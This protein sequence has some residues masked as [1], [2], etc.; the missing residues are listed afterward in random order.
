MK[1]RVALAVV[2][3]AASLAASAAAW[4][5]DVE[6]DLSPG[7]K[8][9]PSVRKSMAKPPVGPVIP[10][11]SRPLPDGVLKA[12]P[13][14]T[15]RFGGSPPPPTPSASAPPPP[16]PT[17]P[18]A[19]PPAG[20]T[21]TAPPT[22]PPP[23]IAGSY[24]LKGEGNDGVK[25]TGT[26]TMS[27]IGGAMY[28]AKWVIGAN[29]FTGVCVKETWAL[30]CAWAV[31][32][33]DANVISYLCPPSDLLDGVWFESGGTKLGEEKLAPIGKPRKDGSGKYTITTGQNPDGST[34]M[35]SLMITT[36]STVCAACYKLE[37]TIGSGT[38]V[39]LGLRPA[40]GDSILGAAFADSGKEYGVIVY[41]IGT[42][43]VLTGEWLQS[44]ESALS[45]GKETMTKL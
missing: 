5:R 36:A 40:F 24:T 27:L 23:S 4:P 43:K 3:V 7:V 17:A 20:A 8:A 11:F 32:A 13:G 26:G 29:T 22:S 34:Y 45:G 25:Y 9:A 41:R 6:V 12:A 2:A 18:T 44:I 35:G 31:K 37:W 30:V 19:P 1:Q 16:P 10:F 15:S 28:N 38:Q 21:N 42:G 14:G 39:G 33:K